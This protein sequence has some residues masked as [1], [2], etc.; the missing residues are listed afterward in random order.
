MLPFK[1]KT[2]GKSSV[3][4]IPLL[5]AVPEGGSVQCK[6]SSPGALQCSL[7]LNFRW[8]EILGCSKES[9]VLPPVWVPGDS[10]GVST[11]GK[12][13]CGALVCCCWVCLFFLKFEMDL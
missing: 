5:G 1:C 6:T 7:G 12:C 9:G 11:Q 13:F 2:V 4:V 3:G 8:T 10:S